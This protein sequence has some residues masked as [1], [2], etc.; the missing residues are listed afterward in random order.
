MTATVRKNRKDLPAAFK[1]KR[2]MKEW[3]HKV[4]QKDNLLVTVW[5]NKIYVFMLSSNTMHP[6]DNVEH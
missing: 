2:M 6:M 1:V 4:Y 3:D 5:H